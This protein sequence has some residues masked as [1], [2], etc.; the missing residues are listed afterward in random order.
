MQEL[1]ERAKIYSVGGVAGSISLD[2]AKPIMLAILAIVL[3][4]AYEFGKKWIKNKLNKN[5]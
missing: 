2:D 5:K 3:D 4:G 1:Y